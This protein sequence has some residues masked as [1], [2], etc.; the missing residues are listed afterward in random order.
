MP[1][2]D[3][4]SLNCHTPSRALEKSASRKYWKKEF[5]PERNRRV[6]ELSK[7]FL[8]ADVLAYHPWPNT[9]TIE[10]MVQRSWVNTLKAKEVE[11]KEC[12]PGSARIPNEA[13]P[14]KEPDEVFLGI[15]SACN[16][17]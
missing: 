16:T 3:Q 4:I 7:K 8:Q 14:T 11:R 17:M 6:H 15:V 13:G 2:G 5:V 12:Y 1:R 9:A 10:G